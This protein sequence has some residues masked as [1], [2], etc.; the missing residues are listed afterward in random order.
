MRYPA[1]MEM[2][3]SDALE[4]ARKKFIEKFGHEYID[5]P[6]VTDARGYAEY[7]RYRLREFLNGEIPS[8]KPA[9]VKA[10]P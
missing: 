5:V 3:Q 1:L 8:P 10:Q 7:S 9:I 6:V 4:F 2:S